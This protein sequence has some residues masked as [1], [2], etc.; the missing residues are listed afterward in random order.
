LKIR[1]ANAPVSWGIMEI[2]GRSPPLPYATFLD[3]LK[4]AGYVATELGPYGYLPTEPDVIRLELGRR[5]LCMTGAFVPLRLKERGAS[6]DE[7]REVGKLLSALHVR[8]LILADQLW[9]EREAIA[10]RVE[11][12]GL[13]LSAGEWRIAA[14]NLKAACDVAADLGLRPVFHH[15]VGTYIESPTEIARLLDSTG[16]SLCLDTGHYVYG[17]G[18]PLEAIEIFG[19]RLEYLHFKDVDSD[20]LALVRREKRDFGDGISAGV[21]CPL[22]RGCVRFPALLEKLGDL[23]FDGWVVVEQDVDTRNETAPK[24]LES[25]RASREYL[26]KIMQPN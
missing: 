3:E 11:E 22:G 18:D 10:G 17:G 26:R 21:F 19:S 16:V 9:P 20:R 5:S 7:V 4:S 2:G 6:L 1:L 25:A 8:H 13:G 14:D 23:H 12:N 15:H 24:P